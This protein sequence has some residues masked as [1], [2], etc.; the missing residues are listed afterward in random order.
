MKIWRSFA[1]ALRGWGAAWRSEMHLRFHMAVMLLVII[2]GYWFRIR[3]Y[4]WLAITVCFV[5]V[6]SLELINTA[7]ETLTNMVSPE[8]HPLA[9]KT[10]DVAAAAVL[11]AA[12]GA[13]IVGLI[14]FVP[15]VMS[16]FH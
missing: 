9:G 13:I 4:E 10:K 12:T 8:M 7:I 6:I 3:T 5:L 11:I 15:Y 1:H 14:I 2:A 16:V